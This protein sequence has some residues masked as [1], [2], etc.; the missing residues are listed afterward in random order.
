MPYHQIVGIANNYTIRNKNGSFGKAKL[1]A[2]LKQAIDCAKMPEVYRDEYEMLITYSQK[3][4]KLDEMNKAYKTARNELDDKLIIKY[5]QLTEEEIKDL[6]FEKKWMARLATDI[7]D[8][9]NQVLSSLSSKVL[10]IAKR[11]EHTLSEIEEKTATSRMAV[12]TSL[13]RMGYK[14]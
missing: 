6:L 14:W 10:L 2:A 12:I 11:Y 13:E 8:E 5:S 1:K 3:S 4:S 9:F 7:N